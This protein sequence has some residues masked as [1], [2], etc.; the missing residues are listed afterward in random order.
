AADN[1]EFQLTLQKMSARRSR[2]IV[3]I[4]RFT[5]ADVR[6]DGD[7]RLVGVY[8][9]PLEGRPNHC[10]LLGPHIPHLTG[11]R[12]K[13]E[14]ATLRKKRIKRLIDKIGPNAIVPVASF[15]NGFLD[16]SMALSHCGEP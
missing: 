14:A 9:T 3:G 6:Y 10:D 7:T 1:E 16:Q 11:V 12:S 15:R 5:A 8:D 13:R 2:S 4:A